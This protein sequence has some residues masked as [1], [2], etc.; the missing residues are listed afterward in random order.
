MK[1]KA[2]ALLISS[3]G[4]S[5]SDFWECMCI[6]AEVML[7]PRLTA[8]YKMV[9]AMNLKHARCYAYG[10]SR[11]TASGTRRSRTSSGYSAESMK[12]QSASTAAAGVG[13]WTRYMAHSLI[14]THRGT[15]C[16]IWR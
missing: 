11:R 9:K 16:C 12:K 2:G 1:M 10:I 15:T 13:A 5:A 7:P 4:N 14:L 6:M 3:A 8:Y